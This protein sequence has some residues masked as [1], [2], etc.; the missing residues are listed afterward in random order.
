MSVSVSPETFKA[1]PVTYQ[2]NNVSRTGKKVEPL[3]L[4]DSIK[5]PPL[6]SVFSSRKQSGEPYN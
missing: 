2:R 6:A 3:K 4:S 5:F 1:T